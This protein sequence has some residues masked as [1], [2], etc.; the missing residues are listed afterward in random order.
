MSRTLTAGSDV[1]SSGTITFYDSSNA[2]LQAASY[3]LSVTQSVDLGA[4]HDNPPDY[5]ATQAVTVTAPRFQLAPQDVQSVYPP[6][7]AVGSFAQALPQ[8]VLT[9]D[10]PWARPIVPGQVVPPQDGPTPWLALLVVYGSESAQVAGPTTTTV[11][12]L[13]NPGNGVLPPALGDLSSSEQSQVCQMLVVDLPYFQ[14]VIPAL[15]E[16]ALLTHAREVDTSQKVTGLQDGFWSLV[17]ANRLPDS[18]EGEA[19]TTTIYLVSLEGHA[20]HLHGATI[21]GSYTKIA[22]AALASWTFTASAFPG[23]FLGLL[24]AIGAS[25]QNLPLRMPTTPSF[26]PSSED[27]PATEA[28]ALGYVPLQ[29]SVRTGETTTSWYRSPIVPYPTQPDPVTTTYSVSDHA[30]RYDPETGMFDDSYAAA[31]QVGRLLALND[32][33]FTLSMVA[34][35]RSDVLQLQRAPAERATRELLALDAAPQ[36]AGAQGATGALAGR[37]AEVLGSLKGRLPARGRRIDDN[38]ARGGLA[39]RDAF[40]AAVASGEDPLDLLLTHLSRHR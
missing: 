10:L 7:R 14:S 34:W 11:A 12:T 6:G 36:A 30:I 29:N 28:L 2:P 25:G 24:Q 40:R 21:A 38:L 33:A 4:D 31:W 35:R 20:D 3:T 13:L 39:Q 15:D 5:V 16:L 22:L 19:R 27:D 37:V 23:D 1:T 17:V 18:A 9:R 32:A 26:T 8:I